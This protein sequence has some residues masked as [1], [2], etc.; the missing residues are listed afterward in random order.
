[1]D[2][3]DWFLENKYI[4]EGFE[5]VALEVCKKE[6]IYGGIPSVCKGAIDMM[7]QSVVPAIAEGILSP[8]RICDEYFGFCSKP[9]ITELHEETF[10]D[11]VLKSKPDIIKNN[12]FVN[13]LYKNIAADKNPR[14]IVRSIQLSDLHIDYAYTEGA[15]AECNFPICCRSNGPELIETDGSKAAGKWGEA[16]YDC[17]VPWITMKSMF[18]FIAANQAEFKT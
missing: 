18:D 12:D 3:L 6:K 15:A 8:S 9:V 14:K 2:P 13:N 16:N 11:R 5:W 10:V 17:D 7:A 1:M 4:E